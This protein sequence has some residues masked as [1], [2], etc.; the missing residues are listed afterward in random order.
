MGDVVVDLH[1]LDGQVDLAVKV[2]AAAALDARVVA[3]LAVGKDQAA[4]GL[5]EIDAAAVALGMVVVH[6]DVVELERA[7]R[8][9]HGDTRAVTVAA[10]VHLVGDVAGDGDVLDVRARAARG[11]RDAARAVPVVA[12]AARDQAALDDGLALAVVLPELAVV[13]GVAR[14]CNFGVRA[15]AAFKVERTAVHVDDL[16]RAV[17]VPLLVLA[18]VEGA[19]AVDHVAVHVD[20][21]GVAVGHL[22]AAVALGVPVVHELDG[23]LV[24]MQLVVVGRGHVVHDVHDVGH[25]RAVVGAAVLGARHLADGTAGIRAVGIGA[26][27][28]CHGAY[29]QHGHRGDRESRSA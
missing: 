2:D 25:A 8:S 6:L 12:R 24:L 14:V 4:R 15:R 9:V 21:V 19:V 16:A 10:G 18:E 13:V 5:A 1:I 26:L 22:D 7:A 27:R 29:E 20:V 11:E 3:D 23:D 28:H 17:G